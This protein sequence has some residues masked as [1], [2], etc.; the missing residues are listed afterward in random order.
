MAGRQPKYTCKEQIEGLID[1]YFEDCEGELLRDADGSPVLDKFSQPIYVGKHPPTS[2]GLARALGF[3]SRTSL[4]NYRG[5]KEFKDTIDAAMLRLEE[6]TEQRLF[7]RDGINGARFSLQCNFKQWKP[8]PED[9]GGAPSITIIND[10]PRVASEATAAQ[11][12]A[13][14]AEVVKDVGESS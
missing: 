12:T 13:T 2:A 14:P 8:D 9:D 5:K 1:Q 6:Y 7:D 11:E 4:W 3:N 10:I